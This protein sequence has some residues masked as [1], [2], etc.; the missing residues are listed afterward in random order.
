MS[1]TPY[2]KSSWF[3]SSSGVSYGSLAGSVQACGGL[4]GSVGGGGGSS[5]AST[6]YTN[7]IYKAPTTEELLLQFT[8]EEITKEY[9]R[10][11]SPLGKAL[12]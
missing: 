6:V 8:D 5:M 12:E 11:C 9:L 2:K 3:S 4:L 1:N 7:F 10:R